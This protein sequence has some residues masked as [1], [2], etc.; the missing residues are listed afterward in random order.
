MAP[1]APHSATPRV[2]APRRVLAEGPVGVPPAVYADARHVHQ[3]TPAAQSR[4]GCRATPSSRL[5][6][7]TSGVHDDSVLA[8]VAPG[9][10]SSQSGSTARRGTTCTSTWW[11]PVEDLPRVEPAIASFIHIAFDDLRR[12]KVSVEVRVGGSLTG[13]WRSSTSD[14]LKFKMTSATYG[15]VS[16]PQ[17]VKAVPA[18]GHDPAQAHDLPEPVLHV[19]LRLPRDFRQRAG[20]DDAGG[21]ARGGGGPRRPA[22]APTA[23]SARVEPGRAQRRA[24]RLPGHVK[25][26]KLVEVRSPA[27][28]AVLR[29]TL[30]TDEYRGATSS[31]WPTTSRTCR[32][33]SP[34]T[35]VYRSFDLACQEGLPP[36]YISANSGGASVWT[37]RSRR[38]SGSSGRTRPPAKGF[39]TST[40]PRT[41][42]RRRRRRARSRTASWTS[43]PARFA[44]GITDVCGGRAWSASRGP[45]RSPP[46]PPGRTRAPSRWRTSRGAPSASARTARGCASA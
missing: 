39:A 33:R 16:P 28:S 11:E 20:S 14:A 36:L 44:G 29:V 46:P 37:R 40:R 43:A 34:R 31:W 26:G 30:V 1:S 35:A 22:R 10:W 6:S 32:R 2:P 38:R 4:G 18:P 24:P 17:S 13:W 9:R 3:R 42:S 45:A 8:D 19:R 12:L 41:T 27:N 25:A 23:L 15:G 7:G 5:A 21:N